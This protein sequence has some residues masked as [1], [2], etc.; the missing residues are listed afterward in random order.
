MHRVQ[1]VVVGVFVALLAVALAGGAGCGR[2]DDVRGDPG[3]T[4][5]GGTGGIGGVGGGTGGIGG[6]GTGDGGD[7]IDFEPCVEVN[8]EASLTPVSMFIAVDISGSMNDDNKWTDTQA[9]FIAFFQDAGAG[10]L[11]VALR[12]WPDEGCEEQTC[13]VA[14]CATPQ[15]PLDLLSDG[16]HQ[17]AL[18]DE[19][20]AKAPFGSTPTSAALEG[21]AQWAHNRVQQTGGAEK[22]VILLVTDGEAT[23][24]NADI[25]YI[26]QVAADALSADEVLTYAIGLQGSAEA[27]MNAIAAAG[28]TTEGIFIGSGTAEQDLLDALL[29]IAG[30]AVDCS[31]PVPTPQNP[32]EELDPRQVRVEYTD[33]D[34]NA[35]L[36]THVDDASACGSSGGWYY[37]DPVNPTTITLCPSTCTEV[38][39]DVD[40]QMDIALGCECETH[41]DCPGIQLCINLHCLDPCQDDDD[42]PGDWICDVDT[43]LCGPP[44]DDNGCKTDADCAPGFICHV[45]SG[46]CVPEPG[47]P[48]E[49]DSDCPPLM[50]LHDGHCV[51]G[52]CVYGDDVMVG[53]YEAVQGG[54]FN[55]TAARVH[56]SRAVGTWLMALVGLGLLL[57]R[58][59]HTV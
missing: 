5:V 27:D 52:Q 35:V 49:D 39:G 57:V 9:A 12:F 58:R 17:Q 3:T 55:C 25:N 18:I 56:R 30:D 34:G 32:D 4:T 38:Q 46:V 11:Q 59:R 14:V 31:F 19:F 22:V 44:P 48:C 1:R 45:E 2:S 20:N 16:T 53:P 8:E 23:T 21:A 33:G 42:C 37:D 10:S 6:T 13:D 7:I 29:A 43:G 41:E 26:S 15:V 50:L 24:C 36:L 40:A 54:A 28:G 47:D 51:G